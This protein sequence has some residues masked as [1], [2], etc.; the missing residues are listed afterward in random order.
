MSEP[1]LNLEALKKQFPEDYNLHHECS[2]VP[3][4]NSRFY[5]IA[6]EA[7]P[8][9]YLSWVIHQPYMKANVLRPVARVLTQRAEAAK[10]K[11]ENYVNQNAIGE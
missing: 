6:W 7:C 8:T 3:F 5:S 4:K 11:A 10:V 1:E 2:T 9:W